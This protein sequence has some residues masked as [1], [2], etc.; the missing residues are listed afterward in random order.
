VRPELGEAGFARHQFSPASAGQC[1]PP[2]VAG[3]LFLGLQFS[4]KV[5]GRLGRIIRV[6]TYDAVTSDSRR[7]IRGSALKALPVV[8]SWRSA[9]C[10]RLGL[11]RSPGYLTKEIF[12]LRLGKARVS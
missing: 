1:D 6:V 9:P 3:L 12:G 7:A 10:E 2:F 5:A 8:L 11:S 4:R